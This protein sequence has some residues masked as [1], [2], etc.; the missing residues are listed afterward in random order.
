MMT[1]SPDNNP[2]NNV[3]KIENTDLAWMQEALVLAKQA[4]DKNE[5]P[6]GAIVVLDNKIIGQGI[7]CPISLHDPTAHAE[8][9]A[10]RDAAK[11]MNNYRLLNATLYVTLAPCQMCLAAMAHARIKR[12]VYGAHDVKKDISLGEQKILNHHMHIAGGVL[13]QECGLLLKKFFEAK[14]L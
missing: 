1:D 4:Q 6:I 5:V 2:D 3:D 7:N 13:E 9:Q 14:R 10:I 8:V 11:N 12:L